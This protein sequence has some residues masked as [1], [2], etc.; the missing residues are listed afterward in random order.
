MVEATVHIGPRTFRILGQN[1]NH[2]TIGATQKWF[3]FYTSCLV[4]K[5]NGVDFQASGY[6]FC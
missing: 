3:L 6:L 5:G 1:A 4:Y 2:W